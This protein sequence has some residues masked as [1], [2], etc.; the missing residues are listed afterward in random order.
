MNMLVCSLKH[1][2]TLLYNY[3]VY[4]FQ[5]RLTTEFV[6]ALLL[7]RPSLIHVEV[8]VGK[9]VLT[10]KRIYVLNQFAE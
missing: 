7:S 5:K 1:V 3:D 9:N 10:C 6:A 4:L 2:L 8:L